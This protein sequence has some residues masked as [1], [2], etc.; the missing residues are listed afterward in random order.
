MTFR[1]M[2]A[3]ALALQQRPVEKLVDELLSLAQLSEW[4]FLVARSVLHKRLE[5]EPFDRRQQLETAAL[6][7]SE[8]AGSDVLRGRIRALVGR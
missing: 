6:T 3:F 7:L 8:N 4:K 2:E 1:D 5:N